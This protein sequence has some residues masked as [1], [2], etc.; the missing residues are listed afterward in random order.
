MESYFS[1]YRLKFKCH[2]ITAINW[3]LSYFSEL[4]LNEDLPGMDSLCRFSSSL[5]KKTTFIIFCLLSFSQNIIE[6]AQEESK[7]QK[8]AN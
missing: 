2:V 5:T 8:L 1:T 3:Y 7:S 4:C 6:D